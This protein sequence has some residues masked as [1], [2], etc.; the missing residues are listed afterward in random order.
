MNFGERRLYFVQ[1]GSVAT[2]YAV[3]VGGEEALNFR[4]SAV[5]GGG[6]VAANRLVEALQAGAGECWAAG[7][8]VEGS[9]GSEAASMAN[10]R[11]VSPVL[12]RSN[13]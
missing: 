8:I 9:R 5:I 3:G 1:P 13:H 6:L 10:S 7:G 12:R 11:V 4:G 2:R